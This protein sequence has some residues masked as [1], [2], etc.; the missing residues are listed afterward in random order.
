M[1]DQE[2]QRLRP[3]A[4]DVNEVDVQA[5]DRGEELRQLVEPALV[6]PPVEACAP[7][8]DQ[9]LEVLELGPLVPAA[10]RRGVRPPG[11][12]EALAKIDQHLF[13]D[14]D[15]ERADR[16]VHCGDPRAPSRDR[17]RRTRSRRRAR[18]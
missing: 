8:L 9:L 4:A 17:P 12:G 2:R 15:A 16:G 10:A 13:W 18:W 11:A 3:A 14:V 5:A 1:R 7:V 6:R